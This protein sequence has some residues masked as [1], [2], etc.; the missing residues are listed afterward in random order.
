MNL[1]KCSPRTVATKAALLFCLSTA[2]LF[3][4]GCASTSGSGSAASVRGQTYT[5]SMLSPQGTPYERSTLATL[6]PVAVDAVNT[7]L[8]GK[9]YREAPAASA[10]L[11]VRLGGKF[12]PDFKS[13]V[14]K[15]TGEITPTVT[16]ESAQ[17]RVLLIEVLD[18]RTKNTIWS[19]SRAG[20]GA[21]TP[22]PDRIRS[23]IAEMLAPLPNASPSQ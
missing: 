1:N 11:L 5:I 2:V 7:T 4:I 19:D 15:V 18:N 16:T 8:G 13:D 9:G 20:S 10:D 12:A 22:T 23:V 14:S 21:T 6:A 17:H 3:Q